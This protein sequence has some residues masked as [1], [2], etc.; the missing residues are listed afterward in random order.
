MQQL[1][2]CA[3]PSAPMVGMTPQTPRDFK[4]LDHMSAGGSPAVP[5]KLQLDALLQL[6]DDEA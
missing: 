1:R 6:D 2:S 3:A 4:K 5:S